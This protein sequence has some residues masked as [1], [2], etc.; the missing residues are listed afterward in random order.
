MAWRATGLWRPFRPPQKTL[1]RGESTLHVAMSG[2]QPNIPL[3]HPTPPP[4]P[5]VPYDLPPS[6]ATRDAAVA[7]TA[8]RTAARPGEVGAGQGARARHVPGGGES[9]R[10]W[11]ER[12]G[13]TAGRRD[14]E[15]RRRAEALAGGP[16]RPERGPDEGN[17]SRRGRRSFPREELRRGRPETTNRRRRL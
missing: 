16:A 3:F 14:D 17:G 8:R 4:V 1:F 15:R 6:S 7:V 12:R 9:H 5:Y 2:F 13:A 11:H 10:R